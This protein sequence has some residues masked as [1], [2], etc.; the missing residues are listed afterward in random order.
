MSTVHIAILGAGPSGC[1]AAQFLQRHMP[2]ATV[3]I[4][5]KLPV[6]YGLVRY[7]VAPDHI[8]TKQIVQQF[9]RQI[10]RGG[11]KFL[12]NVHVPDVL[13]LDILEKNFHL[14]VCA[15]GLSQDRSLGV[16]GEGLPGVLGSGLLA[17]YINDH[18]YFGHMQ[19]RCGQD[20]AIVGNGNVAI[21]LLRLLAKTSA[22]FSGSELSEQAL[23][24][25]NSDAPRTIHLIGRSGPHEAKFDVVMIKELQQLKDVQF[26]FASKDTE[27][28]VAQNQ[29]DPLCGE[30]NKLV[31][32]STKNAKKE[33]IFHFNQKVECFVGDEHVAEV[34]L[35]STLPGRDNQIRVPVD[36]VITAIGYE[37][38]SNDISLCVESL[39][40]PVFKIGWC[41]KGPRGK[42]PDSRHQAR[43]LIKDIDSILS[44]KQISSK[45]GLDGV[46][47]YLN[48]V[49]AHYVDYEGWLQ[50]DDQ[51]LA[52]APE[53][54]VR[55]KLR[56]VQAML[57]A[58][59][60]KVRS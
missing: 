24:A 36:T 13:P 25:L 18:P 50:I 4:I 15:T 33:V 48:S 34:G 38:Q 21:D 10:E 60:G 8:G 11:I 32:Q 29:G 26:K 2:K 44:V 49:N 41:A 55:E 9:A 58:A 46:I 17:R 28:I 7:G 6:P 54:R 1:Y 35:S 47:T 52:G 5:D 57:E 59:K 56:T 20:V 43:A 51:E 39:E 42:I 23:I 37:H 40:I 30:L 22:E 19:L 16:E 31:Q 3:T 12:G 45:R 27:Q 14:V 53:D